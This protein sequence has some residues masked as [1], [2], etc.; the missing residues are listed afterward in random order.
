MSY[1][2]APRIVQCSLGI[3][4]SFRLLSFKNGLGLPRI[5]CDVTCFQFDLVMMH[6][7]LQ[8]R[9]MPVFDE[10]N[11]S[12]LNWTRSRYSFSSEKLVIF[13]NDPLSIHWRTA[14]THL[15]KTVTLFYEMMQNWSLRNMVY[16]YF[17]FFILFSIIAP[18]S[19][20]LVSFVVDLVS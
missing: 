12:E 17:H 1:C 18:R 15:S 2:Y 19:G 3:F 20:W 4:D 8:E 5:L 7:L 16:I 10:F 11:S 6:L 14:W 9:V 13:E